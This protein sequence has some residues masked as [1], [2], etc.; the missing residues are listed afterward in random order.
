LGTICPGWFWTAILLISA[1]PVAGIT[2]V[3]HWC[4][5]WTP[6]L[7]KGENWPESQCIRELQH[8]VVTRPLDLQS[9]DMVVVLSLQISLPYFGSKFSHLLCNGA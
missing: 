7:C 5:A 1:F 9:G 3:S 2:G 8:G 6:L 4:L